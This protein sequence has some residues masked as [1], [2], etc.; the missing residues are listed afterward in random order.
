M[1]FWRGK[2]V[3]I[4]GGA[5]FIGSHVVR[6]LQQKDCSDIF[7]VRSKE[8]DLTKEEDVVCLLEEARPDIVIHLAGLV[9][10][11]S[12][13]QERPAEFFYQNLT[14]GTFML[15]HS[16]RLGVKKFIAAGAGHYPVHTPIPFKE[17]TFWDGLPQPESAPYS[18][19]KRLLHIQSK[20]YFDQY[21][22]MSAIGILA[23][24]YGPNHTFDLQFSPVVPAL[25][26]KCVEAAE[27]GSD[28]VTVWG[29]GRPTRDFIHVSDAARG[30]L[31]AAERYER[32][33]LV[34]ISS[35]TETTIRE[36]VNI[37]T[38]LTGFKGRVVWDASQSDGALR[39]CLDPTKA[40]KEL[41]FQ[42]QIGLRE[43]LE[44]TIAW[45]KEHKQQARLS[46][47]V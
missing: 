23:N 2:R 32:P 18:L 8:H 7:V 27:N 6:A 10:G 15:H 30:L 34:N 31:L 33:Q 25:L 9:G 13:N 20:A 3:L 47:T 19:A 45:Y 1:S 21:G 39:H 35:G 42:V 29:S 38:E 11:I 44:S 37:L 43:G 16:W 41:G 24:V 28:T 36:L 40:R 17:K 4:T 14:M 22:F 46:I 26:R 12:A 5:G